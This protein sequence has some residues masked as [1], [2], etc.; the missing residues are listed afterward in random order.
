MD[1]FCSNCEAELSGYTERKKMA[2]II[3]GNLL[4]KDCWKK[5]KGR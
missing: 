2:T 4:C 1:E 5:Y 3:N